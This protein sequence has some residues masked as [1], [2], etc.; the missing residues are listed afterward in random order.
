MSMDEA[1][2]RFDPTELAFRLEIAKSLGHKG[3]PQI[4]PKSIDESSGIIDRNSTVLKNYDLI[5]MLE[6][7]RRW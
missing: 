3:I 2:K 7:A 4:D 5:K 1:K 6:E